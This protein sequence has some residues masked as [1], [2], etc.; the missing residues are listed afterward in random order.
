MKALKIIGITIG[1][2]IIALI[3]FNLLESET[4]YEKG[5]KKYNYEI[6]LNG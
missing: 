6:P 1:V 5:I 2:T 4:T 3:L